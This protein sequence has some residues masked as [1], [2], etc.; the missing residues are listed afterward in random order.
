VSALT[1]LVGILPIRRDVRLAEFNPLGR[2]KYAA[3][4]LFG[5]SSEAK[6]LTADSFRLPD[7][8]RET[9]GSRSV[10]I[11][12]HNV[13]LIYFNRLNY[14]PRPVFQSYAA[15]SDQLVNLNRKKYESPSA[16][17]FVIFSN[18]AL[19]NRY[20]FFDDTGAKI[21]LLEN[22]AVA[23]KFEFKGNE[24]LLFE[25]SANRKT[26]RFGEPANET[27]NFSQNY[28][29]PDPNKTYLCQIDLDYSALGNLSKFLY[30]PLNLKIVF[31]LDDGRERE[32]RAVVPILKSGVV[33]NPLIESDVDHEMF[34]SGRT[35]SLKKIK[36][37]RLEPFYRN[38]FEKLNLLNY[39]EPVKIEVRELIQN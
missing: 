4:L 28:A 1:L 35:E 3:D 10:D 34:F 16:P 36:S 8:I 11:I 33:I 30:Q 7:E 37:F 38:Y 24:Y 27:L 22:Y 39:R 14:N 25:K 2:F 23:K 12:P 5:E 21:A 6:K 29:L 9:I 26:V 31:A 20:G 15:F 13:D 19:D 17:D 32:F 18:E